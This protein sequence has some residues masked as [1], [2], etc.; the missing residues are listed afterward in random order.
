MSLTLWCHHS[1][2]IAHLEAEIEYL[3]GELTQERQSYRA[4]VDALLQLKVGVG[5]VSPSVAPAGLPPEIRELL[6]DPE[7]Q[8]A[9][10]AE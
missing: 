4:A 9:G 7:F 3:K 10:M 6:T 8:R 5:P 1:H 2:F